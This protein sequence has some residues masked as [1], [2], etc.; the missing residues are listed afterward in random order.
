MLDGAEVWVSFWPA[1]NT[2]GCGFW[3]LVSHSARIASRR[4]NSGCD[5]CTVTSLA[6]TGSS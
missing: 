2:L 1:T 4:A 3:P 6:L 5:T